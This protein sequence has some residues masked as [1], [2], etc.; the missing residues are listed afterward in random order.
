M[1]GLFT[2]W[3]VFS[4]S[5]DVYVCLTGRYPWATINSYYAVI[6]HEKFIPES[7][8]VVC[9]EAYQSSLSMIHQCLETINESYGI[10]CSIEDL[11]VPTAEFAMSIH[12]FHQLIKSFVDNQDAVALD[13]TGGRRTLIASS[14]LTMKKRV[15]SHVF[16]LAV[17]EEGKRD[18][19]YLMK[20]LKSMQI[21]DFLEDVMDE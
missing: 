21:K 19:P 8:Y 6:Y 12:K 10:D 11:I 4:L 20:P 13:I 9:E 3:S 15:A 18:I 1:F 2:I 16:Y 17:T 14:L 5:R 7:I